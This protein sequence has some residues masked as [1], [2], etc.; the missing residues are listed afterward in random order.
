MSQD[1]Q[2]IVQLEQQ[3]KTLIKQLSEVNQRLNFLE[4]ENN[5]RRSDIT[6]IAAAINKRG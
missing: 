1:A 6:Q 3:V 2:K 4:R 5:R